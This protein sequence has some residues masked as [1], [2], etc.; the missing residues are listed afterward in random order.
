L[1]RRQRDKQGHA[2]VKGNTVASLIKGDNVVRKGDLTTKKD[3]NK[4]ALWQMRK[5]CQGLQNLYDGKAA[6][7][8][9]FPRWQLCKGW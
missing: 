2:S 8:A 5:I 3:Y 4:T 7:R 1:G 9:N 6:R